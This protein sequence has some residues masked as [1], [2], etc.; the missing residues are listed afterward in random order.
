MRSN[1]R[2]VETVSWDDVQDFIVLLNANTDDATYR[3]PTD[4]EW[5]YACRAGTQTRFYWG[6]D[7]GEDDVY[8]Y[9]WFV[10]N[11]GAETNPVGKKLPN[12]WGLYDMSGNVFEWCNDYY[13]ANLGNDPVTDPKGP[14]TGPG[15][16]L[17]SSSWFYGADNCRSAN[18]GYQL[19]DE[20]N[21]SIG[22]RLLREQD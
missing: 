7:S 5:E 8:D 6:T 2:P 3:L 12:A 15:R 13:T 9:A 22:F 21:G 20:G 1:K 18:R 19:Q 16:V 10:F 14:D 4:A 11:A 17:R